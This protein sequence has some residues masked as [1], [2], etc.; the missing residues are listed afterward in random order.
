MWGGQKQI[1]VHT[2]CKCFFYSKYL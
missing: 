1:D 2:K